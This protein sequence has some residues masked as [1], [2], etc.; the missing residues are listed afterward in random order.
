[1]MLPPSLSGCFLPANQRAQKTSLLGQL[2]EYTLQ[3][4]ALESVC[5]LWHFFKV[6]PTGQ[7]TYST[8]TGKVF[9]TRLRSMG[10]TPQDSVPSE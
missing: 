2:Q 1:M 4:N 5:S 9:L 10:K 7:I 3:F 8:P 6:F